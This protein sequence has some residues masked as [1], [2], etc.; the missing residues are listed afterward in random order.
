VLGS[1]VRIGAWSVIGEQVH[2][3]DNSVLAP[4]VVVQAGSRIGARVSIGPFS[5]VGGHPLAP[6]TLGELSQQDQPVVLADGL[7]IAAQSRVTLSPDTA[8]E[9]AGVDD[10]A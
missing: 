3:G 4:H 7:Q 9:T 1:N 8:S 10:G 5:V 2:I 6:A